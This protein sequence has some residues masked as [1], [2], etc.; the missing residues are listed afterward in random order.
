MQEEI[1]SQA[2]TPDESRRKRFCAWVVNAAAL[3][4]AS[5]GAIVLLGWY[6]DIAPLKS[7]LPGLITMK[8]NTAIGLILLG[9]SLRLLKAG[10]GKK[11]RRVAHGLA[12]VA[13][14]LA[15]LTLLEYLLGW[16]LGIDEFLFIDPVN[17]YP[18]MMSP[19]TALNF[20]LSGMAL[21]LLD[22]RAVQDHRASEFLAFAVGLASLSAMFGYAAGIVDLYHMAFTT[23][24]ALN[25]SIA[26]VLLAIG[27]LCARTEHG[28]MSQYVSSGPAGNV[29]RLLVPA[30][31]V[32]PL[33]LGLL[34]D[35]ELAGISFLALSTSTAGLL[36][37][38][39]TCRLIY[40][41]DL[42]R[43]S[44]EVQ[45]KT[46]SMA[47]EQSAESFIITD[48][49]G[50][51]TY[52]NPSTETISGYTRE[53]LV[54]KNPRIFKSGIHGQEFYEEF[55]QTLAQGRVWSGRM[56]NKRKDGTLYEEETVISPVRNK[57]G[58]LLHYVAVK[59]DLTERRQSEAETARLNVQADRNKQ[60]LEDVMHNIPGI[61]WEAWGKPDE[62]AQRFDFV[63]NYVETLLGYSVEE[64]LSTPNFW[65]SI[66]D[67]E[68]K[69]RM[70]AD[71]AQHFASGQDGT[72][73]FRWMCKDGRR[74][75]VE[76]RTTTIKSDD[77]QSIGR[78]GV[79]IDITERKN[80][81]DQLRQSQ[82]LEAIGSL[83]GGIAHDF[84]NMLTIINGYSDLAL[85]ALQPADPLRHKIEEIKNAGSRAASLTRQLLIFSR[86]QV[87]QL[88]ALDLNMV[89]LEIDKMLRRLLGEDIE[90]VTVFESEHG[91]I[92]GDRGQIEQIVMNLAVNARDAMPQGGRLT[93]ETQDVILDEE[94][95]RT[96]TGGSPGRYVLLAV[97]DTGIGMDEQTQA[98]IFEPFFTTKEAG[99][100]TGLGLSTVYGIVREAKG[101]V[102]VYSKVGHGTTFKIYFPFVSA[103]APQPSVS[104]W[105]AETERGTETILLAE[106]EDSV[107]K[108][109]RTT[110]E[111]FGYTVLEAASMDGAISISESH[112]GPIHLLFTD[113]IMPRGGGIV[114]AHRLEQTRPE[115][116]VL[117]MSGYTDNAMIHREILDRR[118]SF[119]QK[120]L[121]VRLIAHK[122]REVLS[123]SSNVRV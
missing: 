41:E 49:D 34:A 81:E 88:T 15:L 17:A 63:S 13:M 97:S 29:A 54:G 47:V 20:I 58:S 72:M 121:D 77:G 89:I 106:D 60:Q 123:S 44:A 69:E 4:V 65:L 71:S 109:T 32:G 37:V 84:N 74:V 117:Y 3:A 92:Q 105:P 46:L 40:R 36:V 86:K 118:A 12:L 16:N 113:V 111:T 64:W 70:V 19:I 79:S 99:K 95:F 26:F 24:I 94:Y 51:I 56:F 59:R 5:T 98:H 1:Q 78:R 122:L 68:D 116:K 6:F 7:V 21:I 112:P 31:V 2:F 35:R 27:I 39:W 18:G 85:A 8:A 11:T 57:S 50:T 9:A 110:L 107:R 53:E 104:S 23:P 96:R 10:S 43:K 76:S 100:G 48:P 114:L 108:L 33:C 120:P 101:F 93:I 119:I 22:A 30:A 66:V 52:V 42:S 38:Y 25:T 55:W 82:K 91:A 45:S 73:E 62:A 61:V 80:L 90:F 75:W 67:P 103:E 14:L 115:M 87:I 83:A 102:T 28:L